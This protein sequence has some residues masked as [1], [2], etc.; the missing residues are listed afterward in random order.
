[1]TAAF[2]GR[3]SNRLPAVIMA[4]LIEFAAV[5]VLINGL[6]A[7]GVILPQT[8]LPSIF[9]LAPSPSPTPTPP[10]PP[11]QHPAKVAGK[12]APPGAK[13]H[14]SPVVAA[15]NPVPLF[16]VIAAITPAAGTEAN[17][18]AAVQGA[19][20]GAGGA[21]DGSGSGGEGQGD[22]S[23]GS[24]A[25]LVSGRIK[26]SDYPYEA[27]TQRARGLVRTSVA[28]DARGHANGCRVTRSS[29][30]AILDRL[31]CDLIVKRFRFR[32]ARD[33]AG[34]AV[35]GSIGYDHEWLLGEFDAPG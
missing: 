2:S 28:I 25:E 34:R 7:G 9:T 29:G 32:A 26:D 6:A 18:G 15:P 8:A 17:N 12:S 10:P 4:G 22:G 24:E 35:A 21:G 19:G 13:A 30:F 1:M 16:P 3:S 31:T 20:S 27:F 14:A 33:A 23:G 5:F 11:Q